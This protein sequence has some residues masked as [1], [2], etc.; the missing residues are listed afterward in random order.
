MLDSIEKRTTVSQNY[1]AHIMTM[2][3]AGLFT[4]PAFIIN[5]P[6]ETSE[7]I[8]ETIQFVKS[9]E[10]DDVTFIAKYAQPQPG[11]PLYEFAL[12]KGMITDEDEYLT[13]LSE[14]HPG[15]LEGAFKNKTLFNFSGQPLEKRVFPLMGGIS[16][17]CLTIFGATKN[18]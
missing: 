15:D 9:L 11:T 7:T 3:E 1:Q 17:Y 4:V 5:M 6:G 18:L 14:I 2:K 10:L 8:A 12:L 16:S 13:N